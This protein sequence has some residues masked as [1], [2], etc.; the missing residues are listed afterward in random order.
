MAF[1]IKPFPIKGG[2]LSFA[3]T[4]EMGVVFLF[5][6]VAS[7][8]GYRIELIQ[9]RFPDCIAYQ[10]RGD[11]EKKV[12]IEF[13]FRSS[14]FRVHGH[15]PRLCD[16]IVCWHHDWPEVP[17]RI[18]VVELKRF[19]GV[20]RKVWIQQA[21]KSQWEFLDSTDRMN[22][23]LSKNAT[24]G[25]IHLIYRCAPISAITDI[26]AFSGDSLSRGNAGWREGQCYGGEI[27]RLCRLNSPVFIFDLRND[28]V[29]R[30]SSFVRRNMQ[31]VGLQA[32]QYWPHLYQMISSRNPAVR[33][34]LR[35][36]SPDRL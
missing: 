30:T 2:V 16:T 35:R 33:K 17:A 13:E 21:L 31:G 9:S 4:N 3:P 26:F 14:N 23:A 32:T 1:E 10:R 5:A 27:T 24:P 22:W 36:I 29:L 20:H 34:E 19:F 25:D 6:D 28:P 7:K 12:R 11:D 8:L 15:S 18:E